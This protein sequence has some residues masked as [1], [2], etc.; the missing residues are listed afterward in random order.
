M[1]VMTF[2]LKHRILEDIFGLWKKRYVKIVDYIKNENPDIIGVQELTRKGKRFL[3]KQF[4][5]FIKS[6]SSF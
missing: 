2:N 4:V 3:K 6:T 1:K 5:L